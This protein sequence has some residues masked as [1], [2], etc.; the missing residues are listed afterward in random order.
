V[1]PGFKEKSRYLWLQ[2]ERILHLYFKIKKKSNT[3]VKM[4]KNLLMCSLMCVIALLG[5]VS[6]SAVNASNEGVL[7]VVY[8][9]NETGNWDLY[10][11]DADGQNDTLLLSTPYDEYTPRFSPDGEEIVFLRRKSSTEFQIVRMKVDGTNKTVLR[12]FTSGVYLYEWG[13]SGWINL[14]WHSNSGCRYHTLMK[15]AADGSGEFVISN[16]L[17]TNAA[18]ETLDGDEM[19]YIKSI[20]CWT[21]RNEIHIMNMDGS[22]DRI[23][24]GNDGYAD[25]G[26]AY[27]HT[28]E[29]FTWSKSERSY[30]PPKNIY[31]MNK[32]G[33]NMIQL[34]NIQPPAE[35]GNPKYS[36]DDSKIIFTYGYKGKPN[37]SGDADLVIMDSNGD[38]MVF[39]TNRPGFQGNGDIAFVPPVNEAPEAI[40]QDITIQAESNCQAYIIPQDIDNGSYDP[41]EGD[42]I[43]LTCDNS[44][45]FAPGVNNVTLTVTDS[46]GESDTCIAVVTVLDANAP[47]FISASASPDVLW[48]PNHKMVPVTINAAVTDN[49]S[50]DVNVKITSVSCNEPTDGS[51]WE[52]TGDLTLNLR[53]E[54]FG[55]GTGRIYTVVL[56]AM[57]ANGN[58]STKEVF[59]TVPH[60]QGKGKK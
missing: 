9:S 41:D 15:V 22:N 11:I 19:V 54:R 7:K 30:L 1:F 12:T 32:D 17:P 45:P 24:L 47:V 10:I 4:K 37:P 34:T 38:N 35:A 58:Q 6:L 33:S 31:S 26:L 36:P 52:I 20:P 27:A 42:E 48:P 29:S 49:C 5:Y 13:K 8:G 44:G 59:I 55:N 28:T 56:T 57:D 2:L 51:D 43:T 50:G 21:P 18:A 16:S 23:L 39:L 14:A 40:C 60:D 53:A 3:G 46:H 25:Y